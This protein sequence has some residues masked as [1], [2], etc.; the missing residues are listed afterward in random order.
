[1]S[2]ATSRDPTRRSTKARNWRWFSTNVSTRAG[3]GLDSAM[4][5]QGPATEDPPR[6]FQRSSEA[7]GAAGAGAPRAGAGGAV[8]GGTVTEDA[9]FVRHDDL[10]SHPG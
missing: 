10:L 4:G 9:G 6:G 7:A 5:S 1:M 8:A 3:L 2:S